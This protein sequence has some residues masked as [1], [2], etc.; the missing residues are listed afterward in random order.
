MRRLVVDPVASRG[1]LAARLTDEAIE[2]YVEWRE[3]CDAV[4]AT[5]ERSSRTAGVDR[6]MWFAAYNA[7]LDREECA[8]GAFAASVRRLGRFLRADLAPDR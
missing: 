1:G 3:E 6:T 4:R 5:Y 2:R 8:A 7:A